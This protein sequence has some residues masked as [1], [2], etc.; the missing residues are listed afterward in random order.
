VFLLSV[1]HVS[2][3]DETVVSDKVISLKDVTE[4]RRLQEIAARNDRMAALGQVAASVAHE[5]RNPLGAIE[6]FAT[7][8]TRDLQDDPSS[9]RLAEKTVYAAQQ[10]NAVVTN[11]LNHTREVAIHTSVQDLN[12]VVNNALDLIAPQAE[13]KQVEIILDLDCNDLAVEIDS[14]QMNQVILNLI[15]NAIEACPYD[16]PGKVTIKTFS[17]GNSVVLQVCDN[18]DGVPQGKKTKIFEP[19][20][21]MKE[22]GIGLGLALCRRLVDA[23]KGE[24]FEDG[25]GG[26]CFNIKLNK[27]ESNCG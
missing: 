20:F 18:G 14:V 13:S 26:A 27:V 11:L 6:G 2:G 25:A 24:L 15:T 19:F 17:S 12:T 3:K 9:L 1:L 16:E 10:L 22:G 7:L 8:L 4:Q 21:T 23:H 5:V